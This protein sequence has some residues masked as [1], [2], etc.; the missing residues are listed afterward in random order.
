VAD[1]TILG[2]YLQSRTQGAVDIV[3]RGKSDL[4]HRET[5]LSN[6]DTTDAAFADWHAGVHF[7]HRSDLGYD[8]KD[9]VEA[10]ELLRS[11]LQEADHTEFMHTKVRESLLAGDSLDLG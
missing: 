6:P 10:R 4:A 3:S 7:R 5:L 1:S 8:L 9:A 11:K 2:A